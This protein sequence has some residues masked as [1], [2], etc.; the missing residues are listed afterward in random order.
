MAS[1]PASSGTVTGVGASGSVAPL[2]SCPWSLEPQH[3]A[4]T[5]LTMQVCAPPAATATAPLRLSPDS[6]RTSTGAGDVTPASELTCH[7]ELSPAQDL[8]QWLDDA[9]MLGAGGDEPRPSAHS[10]LDLLRPVG[11]QQRVGT[12]VACGTELS[13]VGTPTPAVH[14]SVARESATV[15][16]TGHRGHDIGRKSR[17]VDRCQSRELRVIPN[18]PVLPPA[19]EAPV[20]LEGAGLSPASRDRRRRTGRTGVARGDRLAPGE[21]GREDQQCRAWQRD[22]GH[23]LR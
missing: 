7:A 10:K 3:R 11:V 14:A 22:Q 4:S 15:V 19:S 12:G 18:Q 2:P 21:P 1:T 5:P 17:H 13:A 8:A 6:S 23:G 16:V 20:C 9:G